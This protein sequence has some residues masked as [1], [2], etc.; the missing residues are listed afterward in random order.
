MTGDVAYDVAQTAV[1]SSPLCLVENCDVPRFDQ[2]MQRAVRDVY[3]P[4]RLH[5][6]M[7]SKHLRICVIVLDHVIE[8]DVSLLVALSMPSFV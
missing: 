2:L 1:L 7:D 8:V 5:G 4:R 6:V 3:I